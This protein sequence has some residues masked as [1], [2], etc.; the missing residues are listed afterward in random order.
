MTKRFKEEQD[1]EEEK[2]ETLQSSLD[3]DSL[4]NKGDVGNGGQDTADAK[5]FYP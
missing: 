3:K 5:P 2:G 4:K 1:V